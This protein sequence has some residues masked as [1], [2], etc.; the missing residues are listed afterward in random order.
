[1]T[2]SEDRS[3]P[4]IRIN[5]HVYDHMREFYI[6]HLDQ[7]LMKGRKYVLSMDFEAQLNDELRGF[8]R[9]SYKDVNGNDRQVNIQSGALISIQVCFKWPEKGNN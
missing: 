9:S 3:G 2:P 8:Y 6:A 7:P 5:R 4:G 1:M